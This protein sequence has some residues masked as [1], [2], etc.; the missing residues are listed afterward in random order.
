MPQQGFQDCGQPSWESCEVNWS[1]LHEPFKTLA[2]APAD[3]EAADRVPG[4]EAVAILKAVGLR[5]LG[6]E[7]EVVVA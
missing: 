7:K 4:G 2:G 1:P 3:V 6:L 5:G